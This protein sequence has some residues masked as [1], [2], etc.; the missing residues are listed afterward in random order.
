MT[1]G[2][3]IFCVACGARPYPELGP[4]GTRQDFGLMR[5]GRNGRPAESP[6]PG[7]WFCPQHFKRAIPPNEKTAAD[8]ATS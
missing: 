3:G 1:E 6:A 5:L 7:E 8:E 4:P 2:A